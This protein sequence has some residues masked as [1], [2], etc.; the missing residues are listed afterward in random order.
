MYFCKSAHVPLRKFF[1]V[2]G[3]SMCEISTFLIS[4]VGW[5]L[6][7]QKGLS[8]YLN[9]TYMCQPMDITIYIANRPSIYCI[10]ASVTS[11]VQ[12][13][14]S[15][16]VQEPHT[17]YYSFIPRHCLTHYAETLILLGKFNANKTYTRVIN[18]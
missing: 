4:F 1:I 15:Q 16:K 10:R 6:A 3:K 11:Y 7:K 5:I 2:C 9:K 12:Y 14:F 13:L 17:A 18:N 8:K